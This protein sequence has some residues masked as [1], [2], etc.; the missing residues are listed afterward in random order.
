MKS[1]RFS[2][3]ALAVIVLLLG[4]TSTQAQGTAFTYQGRL[5]A[6]S[7]PATGLYDLQFNLHAAAS[8]GGAL[9]APITSPGTPVTN[10]LFTVAL[11]F[12]SQ[13]PGADRW[14]EIAART[15]GGGVFSTLLC[16]HQPAFVAIAP[17]ASDI[18]GSVPLFRNS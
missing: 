1:N 9:T 5:D 17:M 2:L 13:F 10:G 16:R 15:N 14:L 4:V 7:T 6:D 12:G 3:S 18:P 11:D 8:G